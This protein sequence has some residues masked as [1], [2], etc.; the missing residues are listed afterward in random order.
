MECSNYWNTLFLIHGMN[1]INN[2]LNSQVLLSFI[3]SCYNVFRSYEQ[4]V[5]MECY[6][7]G[8][9][10]FTWNEWRAPSPSAFISLTWVRKCQ[11]KQLN[12]LDRGPTVILLLSTLHI[13]MVTANLSVDQGHGSQLATIPS[14]SARM[15]TAGSLHSIS[16]RRH[17]CV[18]HGVD[19]ATNRSISFF[20][21]AVQLLLT[22][23][24]P[25]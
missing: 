3:F 20:S 19:I 4:L 8:N 17:F 23:A 5:P 15:F 6:I 18:I 11:S 13:T 21:V 14:I 1:E 22:R 9:L 12:S 10:Q 2:R 7:A 25:L 16:Y 24:K